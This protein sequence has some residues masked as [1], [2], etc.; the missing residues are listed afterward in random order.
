MKIW[1]IDVEMRVRQTLTFGGPATEEAARSIVA[2]V[3]SGDL[4]MYHFVKWANGRVVNRVVPDQAV[5]DT[6][7]IVAVREVPE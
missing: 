4:D 7:T 1:E 5:I 3:L 2:L 6:P